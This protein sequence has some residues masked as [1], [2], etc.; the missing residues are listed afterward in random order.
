MSASVGTPKERSRLTV[1]LLS[2]GI[3]ASLWY[4]FMNA[5]TAMRFP[6]YSTVDQTIS[7]LS[8]L[9]APTRTLWVR[10]GFAYAL[11]LVA[12]G[13][14]VFLAAHGKRALR[15]VGALLVTNA[16]IGIAWPPMHLRGETT[17]L[18]DTLHLVWTA[19]SIPMVMVAIGFGAVAFGRRFRIYSYV[20]IA[21]MLVFGGLTG[22]YGS[23][24]PK[25]LETPFM[26]AYERVSAAAFMAWWIVLAVILVRRERAS[27]SSGVG[28]RAAPA[29]HLVRQ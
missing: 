19:V 14:G 24:I 1:I 18:T 17:S 13:V 12:F 11:F 22:M 29:R 6:G 23:R 21:A 16:L 2:G 25:G 4:V 7:E 26:G 28:P 9:G 20:T 8:A 3:F 27:Y 15:V 10:L 5:I